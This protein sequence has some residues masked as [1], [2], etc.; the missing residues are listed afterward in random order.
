MAARTGMRILV[1]LE[2]S[3]FPLAGKEGMAL[4][5]WRWGWMGEECGECESEEGCVCE[6]RAVVSEEG[7]GFEIEDTI[8]G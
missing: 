6:G 8:G 3:R 5:D 4:R 2:R 1:P 7:G